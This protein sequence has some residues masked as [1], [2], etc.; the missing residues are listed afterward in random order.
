MTYIFSFLW[1]LPQIHF[2]TSAG[3]FS[4]AP[5]C[6]TWQLPPPLSR[7]GQSGA[8]LRPA[9]SRPGAGINTIIHSKPV[10]THLGG[11]LPPPHLAAGPAQ[12]WGAQPRTEGPSP[13]LRGPA[14]VWGAQPRTEGPSPGLR[15][16]DV[17]DVGVLACSDFGR[18][19]KRELSWPQEC[20]GKPFILR[21]SATSTSTERAYWPC[22]SHH[23][24]P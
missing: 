24:Q 8:T 12:V 17:R 20:G 5:G 22:G 7:A 9:G 18:E 21:P 2:W 1:E 11:A 14:P 10:W 3:P 13:G 4:Y 23:C 19:S 6:R 16:R 15:A